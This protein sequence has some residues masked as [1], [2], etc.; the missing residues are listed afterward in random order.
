MGGAWKDDTDVSQVDEICLA[1]GILAQH[2]G[3]QAGALLLIV[4]ALT[5]NNLISVEES[6]GLVSLLLPE[7]TSEPQNSVTAAVI[8]PDKRRQSRAAPQTD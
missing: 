6:E 3:E 5:R 7:Q 2:T 4:Q 1:L 8:A